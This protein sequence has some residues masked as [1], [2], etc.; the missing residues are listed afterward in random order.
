MLCPDHLTATHLCVS[1]QQIVFHEA[2]QQPSGRGQH[3]EPYF[4]S[5]GQ[6]KELPQTHSIAGT[7]LS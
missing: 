1:E 2:L 4:Q 7:T 3:Q 6:R 5:G